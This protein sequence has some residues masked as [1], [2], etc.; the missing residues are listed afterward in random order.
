MVA[1]LAYLLG[2]WWPLTA[3]TI[4]SFPG[5]DTGSR[6]EGGKIIRVESTEH[7]TA[8]QV[9]ELS[10]QNFGPAA[11]TPQVGVTK[12]VIA[13]SSY[14]KDDRPITVYGRM[15]LPD[16]SAKLPAMAFAPGT[17][18]IGDQCAASL[19]QPKRSNWANYDSHM[20]TYAGQGYAMTTTDYEGMRDSSRIHHYMIGE[21]EGR[22]LLDGLQALQNWQP[23]SSRIDDKRLFVGGYSQG[24][25]AAL[26]A[27]KLAASYAPKVKLQGV[28]GFGPVTD[29]A[30]TLADVTRG[31][32]INWFGPYVLTSYQ[33]YYDR[34][35][36]TDQILEP[37][38]VAPLTSDVLKNCIDTNIP[39]WGS[40]PEAVYTPAFR[41]ALTS[42]QL[43]SSGF[44]KLSQ[45]MAANAA[46]DSRTSTPK[47]INQGGHDNVILPAQS[48]AARDRLCRTSEASISYR[49]YPMA[50][51]YTTMV[52]SFQ[53]TLTWMRA[54]ADH[55]APDNCPAS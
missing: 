46:D 5:L 9:H 44:A 16:G 19:E 22:A 21:L 54:A 36:G 31:A 33:D 37:R 49:E 30:R 47:L 24:G 10:R 12:A 43:A 11:P 42:D 48:L 23:A 2:R 35:Y 40:K 8:A 25:H 7:F 20:V 53:D 50:T 15:Y 55:V 14:G 17:T 52:L 32:N 27:D 3:S 26:W 29:V 41:Q 6:L 18:G 38:W 39:Y 34:Q 1:G 45:D 13:Y 51:H 28:V 4:P